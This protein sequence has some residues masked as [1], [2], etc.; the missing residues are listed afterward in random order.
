MRNVS[1]IVLDIETTGL[2]PEN[3]HD[4]IVQLAIIDQDQQVLF[5]QYFLTSKAYQRNEFAPA[6][7]LFEQELYPFAQYRNQIQDIIDEAPLIVAYNFSFDYSFLHEAGIIFDKKPFYCVMKGFAAVY[8]RRNA[9]GD[10][11]RWQTLSTCASYFGYPPFQA[12]D[13]LE[14]AKAT[15]Y[16]FEKTVELKRQVDR[17]NV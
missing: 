2:V 6:E 1:C 8:G 12:H 15:L 5:H 7:S 10:S 3:G 11:W 16:C 14:D 4:E 13:A 9:S 17:S